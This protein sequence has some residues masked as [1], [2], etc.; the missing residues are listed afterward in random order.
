LPFDAEIMICSGRELI[1]AVAHAP[2]DAHPP[3]SDIVRFVNVMSKPVRTLPALPLNLPADAWLV[4]LISVHGRF[5][6]GLYRRQMRAIT[7]LGRL[8]K[9]LGL[10]MTT[11][12]WNTISAIVKVLKREPDCS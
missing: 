6:F 4:K 11:R 12:N 10:A 7:H 2:F 5:L 8:E 9:Q 3:S 1:D